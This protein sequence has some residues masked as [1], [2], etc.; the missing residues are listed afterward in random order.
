M[1]SINDDDGYYDVENNLE[2]VTV[3]ADSISSMDSKTLAVGSVIWDGLH[4][5]YWQVICMW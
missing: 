5:S 1:M 2:T 4:S 3:A